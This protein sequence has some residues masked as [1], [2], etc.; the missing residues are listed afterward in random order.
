MY[1]KKFQAVAWTRFLAARHPWALAGLGSAINMFLCTK[2]FC[3][4][5]EFV[6]EMRTTLIVCPIALPRFIVVGLSASIA[7]L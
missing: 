7:F 1:L 2:L 5:F 3:V 4:L 6:S